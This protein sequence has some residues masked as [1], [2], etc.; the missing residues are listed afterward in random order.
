MISDERYRAK[1]AHRGRGLAELELRVGGVVADIEARLALRPRVR[2]LELGCGYGTAL[3]ELAERYGARVDLHG[4]N[5]WPGD[6]NEAILRR[7]ALDRG[8]DR[9]ADAL[10]TLAYADA[11]PGLPYADDS[12]DLVYSQ[13]AW[14]YFGNK[15]GVLREVMRVLRDDGVAR[16]DAHERYPRLPAEYARLVEIWEDG[17]L[18]PFRDYVRRYAGTQAAASDGGFVRF[19]K[20]AG[21]G[22]DLRLVLE[23]DAAT[24][25]PAWDGVKCIYTRAAPPAASGRALPPLSAGRTGRD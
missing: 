2:V 11:G 18:V 22:E 16:I 19:G 9:A 7:N 17:R 12:F 24:L 25:H 8:L 4:L 15:I 1:L 6:G 5:Q 13:V 21:F 20:C 3:L 23:V 14:P 10:P